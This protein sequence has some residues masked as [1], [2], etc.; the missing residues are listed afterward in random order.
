MGG[1]ASSRGGDLPLGGARAKT[2]DQRKGASRHAT[3]WDAQQHLIGLLHRRQKD[4]LRQ[5]ERRQ[6]RADARARAA[7]RYAPI[8]RSTPRSARCVWPAT[9][10]GRC[11]TRRWSR[12]LL[13]AA[14]LGSR[15]GRV[16]RRPRGQTVCSESRSSAIS[17]TTKTRRSAGLTPVSVVGAGDGTRTHDSLLGKQMLYQAAMPLALLQSAPPAGALAGPRA[18]GRGSTRSGSRWWPRRSPP[19]PPPRGS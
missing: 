10:A 12:R 13:R 6:H 7:P 5:P 4:K 19:C 3:I 2:T 17:R 8:R 16:Q 11:R 14:L 18:A 15:P 1:R 9:T